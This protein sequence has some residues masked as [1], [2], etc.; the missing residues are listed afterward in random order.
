MSEIIFKKLN[1]SELEEELRLI[2]EQVK[3]RIEEL[4]QAERITPETWNTIITI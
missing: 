1:P 4:E 3:Q 2:A